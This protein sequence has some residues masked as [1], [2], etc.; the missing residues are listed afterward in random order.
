MTFCPSVL[1]PL[2]NR[3]RGNFKSSLCVM[4]GM[5]VCCSVTSQINNVLLCCNTCP[6]IIKCIYIFWQ[7]LVVETADASGEGYYDLDHLGRYRRYRYRQF[8][9]ISQG[10]SHKYLSHS[11]IFEFLHVEPSAAKKAMHHSTIDI[12][13]SKCSL[14]TF[15]LRIETHELYI[16]VYN[17]STTSSQPNCIIDYIGEDIM[18]QKLRIFCIL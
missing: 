13:L 10:Y 12:T 16:A 9:N 8:I 4:Y 6:F 11:S 7:N 17:L 2:F 14:I 1:T 3:W 18:Y 5:G 15:Q